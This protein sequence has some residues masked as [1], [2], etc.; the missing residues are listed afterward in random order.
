MNNVINK[1]IFFICITSILVL[2]YINFFIQSVL[3]RYGDEKVYIECG[4]MYI[5]GSPPIN[6]NY[7]HPPLAKY[8]IGLLFT[9]DPWRLALFILYVLSSM[10]V[11]RLCRAIGIG[12]LAYVCLLFLLFDTIVYN[13]YRYYLL[14]PFSVF[15]ALVGVYFAVRGK[16]VHSA[17]FMGLSIASKLQSIPLLLGIVLIY[18]MDRRVSDV[19]KYLVIIFIVYLT[20]YLM[21]L[22]IG[23]HG[24]IQHHLMMYEYMKWRHG[25]SLPIA[26]NGLLRLM[27]RVEWWIYAGEIDVE[28]SK[29]D[30]SM[31]VINETMREING[32]MLVIGVGAGSP[33]WYLL[34]PALLINTYYLFT[35]GIHSAVDHMV[36][37]SWAS[38]ISVLAGPLDWYYVN[39]LP[40]L[41][42]NLSILLHRLGYSGKIKDG[43]FRLI[44]CSILCIHIAFGIATLIG[45]A[46]FTVRFLLT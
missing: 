27:T 22:R 26:L 43:K 12:S 45:V 37:L 15:F 17:V 40:I 25:F 7:E 20:T 9:I 18:V 1:K 28:I 21:D 5:Q 36:I 14:D 35:H 4:L 30:S 19:F 23:V 46:P 10:V 16:L 33:L 11:Y 2:I 32:R 39:T 38:I 31:V 44:L 8:I 41:Y 24:I 29:V 3:P 34:I 13:T 42:I 6:C